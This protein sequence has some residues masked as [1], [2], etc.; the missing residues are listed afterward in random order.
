MADIY[1][2]LFVSHGAP[3]IVISRHQAVTALRQLG[4][5][6]ARPAAIVV[7]SAH[8]MSD[9]VAI[10]AAECLASIHDFAGFPPEL[11]RIEYPAKGE[12][13]LAEEIA[14]ML[15]STDIGAELEPD[16]GLDH[17]AWTPLSLMY[18]DADIPIVQVAL[19]AGGFEACIRL[20]EALSALRKR[21]ILIIGSG[22]S[23]H[24]LRALN[25]QNVT[26]PWALAFEDWLLQ[27]IEGNHF[28]RVAGTN[29]LPTLFRTAHPTPEHYLPLVVAWSAGDSSRPGKRLHHSF[30]YGNIGMSMF[31]FG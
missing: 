7:V 24:N 11:Y 14:G 9:P 20:G 12:S 2:A 29:N 1:P 18:P 26:A 4:R 31:R 23:V 25:R 13:R 30:M 19:P 8:W 28:D 6:L 22:G 27:S 10:T 16:R 21:N 5:Q 17:G 15:Q 3:D